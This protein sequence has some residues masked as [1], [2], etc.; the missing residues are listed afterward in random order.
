M[1]RSTFNVLFYL[2]KSQPKK[3]GQCPVMGRITIDGVAVQFSCKVDVD[4]KIWDADAG[5]AIGR[6]EPARERSTNTGTSI[7][8][9]E[10][11]SEWHFQLHRRKATPVVIHRIKRDHGEAVIP[12]IY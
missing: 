4:P 7:N 10:S 2:K 12:T 9:W 6:S 8:G 11:L 1:R 3:N 5:R